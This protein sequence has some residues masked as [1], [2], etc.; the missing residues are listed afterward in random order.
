[1]TTEVD[2]QQEEVVQDDSGFDAGFAEARGEELPTEQ[3]PEQQEQVEVAEEVA[4]EPEPEQQAATLIAGL[5]EEQVKELLLKAGQVDEL[6]GQLRKAFGR[7]GE[8]NGEIQQ[9]RQRGGV[10][11]SADKLKR[12]SAEY[13]E[14]ADALAEDL[15]G[16]LEAGAPSGPA[17]DVNGF[18]N[19]V[20]QRLSAQQQQMNQ[21]IEKRL[22]T[23]AHRDWLD[24]VKSNDFQLWATQVL[25]KEESTKLAETWDADFI[26]DKL[27]EF[28]EFRDKSAKTQ[29]SKQKRLEAAVAPRGGA[30]T[31]AIQSEEEAFAKAFKGV[32]ESRLY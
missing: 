19:A 22:L 12:L 27:T 29:Q 14:L 24:V 9:L 10:K 16:A 2:Q 30:P 32:R 3:E 23:R 8:V 7:L 13:P 15:S 28:K 11:L 18:S 20:E 31:Q 5:T 21:E 1:M 4:A 25:P 6:S 17:F 26:S